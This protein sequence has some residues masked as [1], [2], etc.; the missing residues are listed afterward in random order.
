MFFYFQSGSIFGMFKQPDRSCSLPVP[1]RDYEWASKQLTEYEGAETNRARVSSLLRQI[2]ETIKPWTEGFLDTAVQLEYDQKDSVAPLDARVIRRNGVIYP[3]P[4]PYEPGLL[5]KLLRKTGSEKVIEITPEVVNVQ[6]IK[7]IN[8]LDT[9][10]DFSYSTDPY[11]TQVTSL[12]VKVS[13]TQDN[14]FFYSF[15]YK[16]TQSWVSLRTSEGSRPGGKWTISTLSQKGIDSGRLA[17]DDLSL[18]E[19][20]K[21][22]KP[23]IHRDLYIMISWGKSPINFN[24]NTLHQWREE[25]NLTPIPSKFKPRIFEYNPDADLFVE[26]YPFGKVKYAQKTL[27]RIFFKNLL[28]VVFAT[29]PEGV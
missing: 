11:K 1:H 20:A 12:K 13:G 27:Q 19:L 18:E 8:G 9:D 5:Y 14:N 21:Q 16:P 4:I 23:F 17:P 6:W 15:T 28:R 25:L 29:L 3:R 22:V 2:E 26:P 10:F 7:T 24:L